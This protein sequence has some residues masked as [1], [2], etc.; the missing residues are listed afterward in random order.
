MSDTYKHAAAPC[1]GCE[2]CADYFFGTCLALVAFFFFW[3]AASAFAFFCAACLLVAFGDLSP[4]NITLRCTATG[5]NSE[6][7]DIPGG[8]ADIRMP[9][10]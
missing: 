4:I 10:N 6:A 1:A 5:V 2:S 7:G 9:N 3:F 8:P